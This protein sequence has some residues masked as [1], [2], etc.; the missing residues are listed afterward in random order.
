ML[1]QKRNK[2]TLISQCI[3]QIVE[4]FG[5]VVAVVVWGGGGGVWDFICVVGMGLFAIVTGCGCFGG[6]FVTVLEW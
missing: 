6:K 5:L 4:V 3:R 1:P 2:L